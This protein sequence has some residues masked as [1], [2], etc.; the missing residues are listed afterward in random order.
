MT[1]FI[2]ESRGR[3]KA[4]DAWVTIFTLKR[5]LI[6]A[7]RFKTRP[8]QGRRSARRPQPRTR[9]LCGTATKSSPSKLYSPSMSRYGW[10][11]DTVDSCI[12]V[13]LVLA[14]LSEQETR[15]TSSMAVAIRVAIDVS[16][17]T[18]LSALSALTCIWLYY[19]IL[20]LM[21]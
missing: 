4:V 3:P 21:R 20:I 16:Y 11:S 10:V 7:L 6:S 2:N 8:R 5:S 15:E 18:F 13:G 12:F 14:V 17:H 19:I 1:V 9:C